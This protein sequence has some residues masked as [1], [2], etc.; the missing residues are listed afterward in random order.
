MERQVRRIVA[1][2]AASVLAL[3]LTAPVAATRGQPDKAVPFAMHIVGLDRP[4]DVSPGIPFVRDLFGG[5]CSAPADWV[6]TV[7]STGF[8]SHLGEVTVVNSHCTR[9]EFFA[10]PNTGVFGD[11]RM[12][13]TADNGDELWLAYSGSFVF[14][15]DENPEVGVSDIAMTLTVVGG[16]GRFVGATGTLH[17]TAVDDFPA[18]PNVADV[19]GSIVYDASNRGKSPS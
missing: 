1:I 4:L 18:G 17:G 9:Y 16:T 15:T 2:L 6:T 3:A 10:T 14:Y 11:G 19:W 13:V 7:D 8:A 5:R 12:T